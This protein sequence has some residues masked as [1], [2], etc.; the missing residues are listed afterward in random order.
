M[1]KITKLIFCLLLFP[2]ILTGQNNKQSATLIFDDSAVRTVLN[3]PKLALEKKDSIWHTNDGY[4]L[5]LQWHKIQE[6]PESYE[7]YEF[8]LNDML[9]DNPRFTKDNRYLETIDKIKE[10]HQIKGD[11]I[12]NHLSSY[13]PGDSSFSAYAYFVAFTEPYAF[14]MSGNLGIDIASPRWHKNPE[15]I[16]NIVIHET[17]HIGYDLYSPDR[18]GFTPK[19]IKEFIE[20][21]FAVIK[22]EG[23]ATYVA[24]RALDII[25]SDY[26][27]RDYQLLEDNEKVDNAFYQINQLIQET[28]I[29]S[30]D[31]LNQKAWVVGV[32]RDRAFY[33]AGAFMAQTIE[34][35][36]GKEYLI[37]LVRQD[38][39]KFIEAYNRIADKKNKIIFRDN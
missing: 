36:Y 20:K 1:K 28:S 30:I 3:N 24:Y 13:L 2:I 37:D 39:F 22:N 35:E 5:V 21:T 19:N 16:I 7:F 26:K 11:L 33:I 8:A 10:I 32:Q 29:A 38:C 34:K 27:D 17:Y 4:K 25:P 15:Y 12:N 9:S 18:L 31:S 14:S 6:V 23:M